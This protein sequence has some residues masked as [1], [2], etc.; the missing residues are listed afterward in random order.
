MSQFFSYFQV[1]QDSKKC[2]LPFFSMPPPPP[3]PPLIQIAGFD[4]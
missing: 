1:R 3:P 4:M 2:P